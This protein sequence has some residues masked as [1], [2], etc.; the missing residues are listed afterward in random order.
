VNELRNLTIGMLIRVA[1]AFDSRVESKLVRRKG[2]KLGR[3]RNGGEKGQKPQPPRPGRGRSR[4]EEIE[5]AAARMG[6]RRK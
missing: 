4:A 5:K 1:H 6:A 2:A 3:R